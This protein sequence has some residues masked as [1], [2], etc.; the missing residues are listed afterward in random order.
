MTGLSQNSAV[1]FDDP[2]YLQSDE[3]EVERLKSLSGSQGVGDTLMDEA[4]E[5]KDLLADLGFNT[6]IKVEENRG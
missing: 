3:A 1:R 2:Y 6:E 4:S 5:Y